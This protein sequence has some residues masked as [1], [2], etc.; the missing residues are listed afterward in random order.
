[1]TF[2][3]CLP[4]ILQSEGVFVDDPADPG[5]A[6]NLGITIDT[7]SGWLGRPATIADVQALTPA[8]V[9]PIYLA[10]YYNPSHACDCAKGLDLMVFDEAVNQGVGRSARSVQAALGVTQDG[11]FGP[12]TLAALRA[13]HPL[14]MI[15]AISANRRAFYQSLATFPR[16]GEGWLNRLAR[17]TKIATQMA[18][19]NG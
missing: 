19:A 15:A 13:S 12:A 5:G 4:V 11:M 10:H 14:P 17:T 9:A 6:T 7:L 2:A 3:A 18:T 1:M 8:T 16:F